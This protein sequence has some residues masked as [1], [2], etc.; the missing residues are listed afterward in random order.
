M[1]FLPTRIGRARIA[2]LALAA[3]SLWGC[4]AP[5][6][7]AAASPERIVAVAPSLVETL[8]ALD[9]GVRVVGVG[10]FCRWPREVEAL[11][12]VGGLTDPR[13]EEIAALS[14]DLAILL[15]SEERL[16]G[17]LQG[18][19]VEVLTVPQE[20]LGEIAAG[21]GTIADRL[22]VVAEGRRL[23]A[24]FNQDLAPA[25]DA[26]HGEV[27]LTVGRPAGQLAG[28]YAAGPGTF[29]DELLRRAGA[30]NALADAPV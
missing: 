15:P 24:E 27:L 23:L 9:V 20:T 22:G 25:A 4:R 10:E 11:P 30:S 8:F 14:P 19:G 12:K 29:L 16:A 7:R 18:L 3:L 21:I 2:V 1:R 6:Q 5:Q 17:M 13:L 26:N 28:L